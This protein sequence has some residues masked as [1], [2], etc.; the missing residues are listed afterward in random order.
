MKKNRSKVNRLARQR[1][2]SNRQ[3]GL[4]TLSLESLEARFALSTVPIMIDLNPSGAAI[5]SDFV[6]FGSFTFFVANNGANG[7]EL[8]KTDGTAQGTTLVADVF[9]GAG[10]SNPTDLVNVNGVLYFSANDGT[11]GREL[12]RSDGT[13][14]GT[15]MVKDLFTGTFVS[16]YQTF[17]NSSN[18]A[19]L[20]NVDGKLFFTARNGVAGTELWTSDG[21]A[22][23][24]RMVRDIFTG[25]QDDIP[26]SSNVLQM[27]NYNGTLY[28]TADDGVHGRELW[29]SDGTEA[30]TVL[31]KDIRTGT[32]E[33][34][35][36]GGAAETRPA[37]SNPA[38]L[39][40]LNGVLYFAANDGA[41]GA[42]LWKSDGTAAGTTLV[43]DI[44]AGTANSF[45]STSVMVEMGGNL[46]FSA[47]DGTNGDELWK[48]DGTE[49]GTTLVKDINP[50]AGGNL[51][52]FAGLTAIDG[53]LYFA[54]DNG[55]TGKE[56]WKSDGTT[57][58]TVM[59]ADL[60]T[61]STTG[62][63]ANGSFPI[64]FT[65]VNGVLY[66]SAFN[67]TTGRELYMLEAGGTPKLVADS[68][69]GTNGLE[70]QALRNINGNLFF[71]GLVPGAVTSA[72]ELF[73]VVDAES[74]TLSIYLNGNAVIIP[75][76]VGVNADGTT[77][78]SFSL[79][80]GGKIY[81]QPTPGQTLGDFFQTWQSEGGLAGN[82]PNA[83]FNSQRIFGLHANA[84]KTIQM[85]VNGQVVR[86]FENYVVQPG[87]DIQII[88]GSNP[89]VSLVTNYG[90]IVIELYEEA[91]PITVANFLKY[92]NNDAYINSIFHRSVK[93]FVIQGG[94]ATTSSET[95]TDVS[96]LTEIPND[97]PITNEP[98]ISNLRGTIAMAKQA[99]DVNSATTQFFVNLS[100]ENDFLDLAANGSFTVFGK[101]LTMSTVDKIAALPI[102]GSNPAPYDELPMSE[103]DKLAVVSTI[104][105]L[106]DVTGVRFVDQNGNGVQDTGEEGLAGVI[107]YVDA[108]S[109]GVFDTNEISAITDADGKY[110]LQ[111]E[112]GTYTIRI[113]LT[114]QGTQTA[115]APGTG[116]TVTVGIGEEKS[117]I[118]FGEQITLKP[119]GLQLASESDTGSSNSDG[120]TNLNNTASKQLKFTVTGLV[121]GAEVRIYAS[122]ALIGTVTATAAEMTV[123]TDG[124]HPLAN[125]EY[126]ITAKQILNGEESEASA[127]ISITVDATAPSAITTTPADTV[128]AGALFS[129]N[130]QSASEGE[131][132]TIYSLINAPT[133]MT[134]DPQTGAIAWT[135]TLSQAMPQ[136]FEIRL[137]DTA[138][139]FAS[140]IVALTVTG[141]IVVLPDL[142][143]VDED[144]VLTVP[145]ASG[146]LNNDGEPG[147]D[148]IATMVDE[149]SHGTLTLNADGSFTY[150]PDAD[151]F[152]TD[153]FTYIATSGSQ[154]GNIAMVTITV[155][156]TDD[157]ATAVA[158]AYETNEDTTLT[159]NAAN[160]VLKNDLNPD[161]GPLTAE[162]VTS[163]AFG[164]L[165][166]NADGSFVYIP[167]NHFHGTVTFT[168][169]VTD[170]TTASDPVT[171]TITVNSVND[172]PVAVPNSY[173]VNEDTTLT[174][175][176][177]T[178]LLSNDQEADGDTLT[179]IV[180][181]NPSHGTLTLNANGSF[182]YVPAANYFG[183]DTFTY[184]A[185]DP[186]GALSAAVTVTITITGV[187]DAPT[188]GND[189]VTVA[190]DG[191]TH[192]INVLT[193]DSSLPDGEQTITIDSVTAGNKGGTVTISSDGLKIDYKP[194]ANF[195]GTETFTYTIKDTDGLTKTATV[196]VTVT[197]A[198]ST[199][200]ISGWVYFD[201]DADGVRDTGEAGVPGV[202][203]TLT[204][205]ATPPVV[206]TAL[207][208]SD[209]SYSF[210][211]LGAGTYKITQSQPA[212]MI[213]G[214]E[215]SSD[216]DAVI[217]NDVISNIVLS[218]TET[219]SANNFGE[220][221]VAPSYLS[222]RWLFASSQANN[223]YFREVI[224]QGEAGAGRHDLAQAIREGKTTY[225][226]PAAAASTMMAETAAAEESA[227]TVS[228]M[229]ES[230]ASDD[231]S[232]AALA[233]SGLPDENED[234][235]SD[236]SSSEGWQSSGSE[237][238]SSQV[239][240]EGLDD[241]ALFG[242]DDDTVIESPVSESDE[243]EI[244][245]LDEAFTALLT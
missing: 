215:K 95:F 168:Y 187:A 169:R 30:G 165:T 76:N 83:V 189:S 1:R 51:S 40:V 53:T 93:D 11:N 129:Y 27:T 71:S 10:S 115:P 137:T 121:P 56:L 111:V 104:E 135:P 105:G 73:T 41:H 170:G 48:S 145:A 124:A 206:K 88:Y 216:A 72:R 227:S 14:A 37:P 173:T 4:R 91:T 180:A 234:A 177:G 174:V 178:G 207:T 122:G 133:G 146:V 31:V 107:V 80:A 57:A 212:A 150:T 119:S 55:T 116:R 109:N 112:E 131:A 185:K 79:A 204:S 101:I 198:S 136:Q 176:V 97:G 98:G 175:P 50:G 62:G 23:G 90:A 64:Y 144:G 3:R 192:S 34:T 120:V 184:R 235:A 99:G 114:A 183:T 232:Y 226:A 45:T 134:I 142:Y 42:E 75:Q 69:P 16:G 139:N 210:T 158:D 35:P 84:D 127:A 66:F 208:N 123:T 20:T 205:A 200:V 132:G 7:R 65:N 24:T 17:P 102:V 126:E 2:R 188:A 143:S 151:F 100:D 179:A 167:N 243:V 29:K 224:A 245:A 162:L 238:P 5:P 149:P 190:N 156:P 89:V 225:E 85:F 138:G 201:A 141:E 44:A 113:V 49:A 237:S 193:N 125:G 163:P 58:G 155:N 233:T 223:S 110:R 8:W 12:W 33:Y 28:F 181:T 130:P 211:G 32:Y 52:Y 217:T 199:G 154:L 46:Y 59:V 61:G 108:N 157:G 230:Q 54:A 94:G 63:V 147:M 164:A 241:D 43:K 152:G 47:N 231:A 67:G 13:A 242:D 106:G 161:G 213:D 15:V 19:A 221:S 103:E 220:L 196:T 39:R 160:G 218:S 172:V 87:D 25:S 195:T 214:Q 240:E 92:I 74:Y 117:G 118:N 244:E 186:S 78:S 96:Q 81:Y 219:V 229:A 191:T 194:A 36:S 140:Q 159:V 9:A 82:D 18:P 171:V 148:L 26:N 153:T 239:D 166:F 38:L 21:T 60:F 228:Q 202:L 182:T 197:T 70:P 77:A 22:A 203:I 236:Y 68:V 6:D 222:I 86:N 209:G 128:A